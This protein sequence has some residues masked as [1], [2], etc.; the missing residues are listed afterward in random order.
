MKGITKKD[1][2]LKWC[3]YMKI[4]NGVDNRTWGVDN[5]YIFADRKVREFAAKKIIRRIPDDESLLR[6]LNKDQNAKIAWYEC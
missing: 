4:F 6:G 3:K 1:C 2:L 5:Y